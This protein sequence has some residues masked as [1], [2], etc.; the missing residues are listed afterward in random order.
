MKEPE[1]CIWKV[2]H[3][4]GGSSF[5][6]PNE[7]LQRCICCDGFGKYYDYKERRERICGVYG[8]LKEIMEDAES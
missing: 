5:Y 8:K 2:S 7:K 4:M 6:K 3:E 1:K